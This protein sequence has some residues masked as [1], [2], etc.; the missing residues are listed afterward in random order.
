MAVENLFSQLLT[1][2]FDV[3]CKDR[4]DL[5]LVRG[6]ANPL[7]K[8]Y[9][10]YRAHA[11]RV[12]DVY[13]ESPDPEGEV[14]TKRLLD[15]VA[16]QPAPPDVK[17][18][19][20]RRRMSEDKS[21]LRRLMN[22]YL[23]GLSA[24]GGP[25]ERVSL[26]DMDDLPEEWEVLK[27]ILI[28]A[29]PGSRGKKGAGSATGR[30]NYSYASQHLVLSLR[31]VSRAKGEMNLDVLLGDLYTD[32][33]RAMKRNAPY[34]YHR[35]L[36]IEFSRM[37]KR[38]FEAVGL[39]VPKK[40]VG[41]R[42]KEFPEPLKSQVERYQV[43]A[44]DGLGSSEK[45]RR[46]ARAY[47]LKEG[48]Y[49]ESTIDSAIA[50]VGVCLGHIT[51]AKGERIERL[52]VEDL[53]ATHFVEIMNDAGKVIDVR[54]VNDNTEI[55]RRRQWAEVTPSKR[56]EFDSGTFEQFRSNLIVVAAVNGYEEH[57]NDFRKGYRVQLDRATRRAKKARKKKVFG[58]PAVDAEILRLSREVFKIV[59]EGSFKMSR[60][61]QDFVIHRRMTKILL[62]VNMA[63]L[64]YLGYRQQCLRRCR[65]GEHV[66]FHADGSIRFDFPEDVTKNGKHVRITL[67]PEEHGATHGVLL[68]I[69]WRYYKDVY[70]YILRRD[71]G[72][73]GHLFVSVSPQTGNFRKYNHEE[74]FE[75]YFVDWGKM[76][77]R[78]ETFPGA[79]ELNLN[80]NP[81]FFRGLCVDWLIEEL[82]W[83]RDAVA[84]FIGDEPETLKEYINENMIHDATKLLTRSNIVLKAEMAERERP[85]AEAEFRA[86]RLE[87]EKALRVK[88][89]QV[90]DLFDQLRMIGELF[91]REKNEKEELLLEIR[92]LREAVASAGDD[93]GKG[94]GDVPATTRPRRKAR[95]T[96]RRRAGA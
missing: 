85:R 46:V 39:P 55:Y 13:L 81:H 89:E 52:G 29:D 73:E 41:L 50:A 37:R 7:L 15:F 57:I 68:E 90:Q 38:Y 82:G 5:E 80:L 11:L 32:L 62:L 74:G 69:L 91:E 18:G 42:L 92:R 51:A 4:P 44:R 6:K 12:S 94:D 78:Y 61:G 95:P 49:R 30:E 53:I 66:V 10:E 1:K 59:E 34:P 83:S 76:H 72:V 21:A 8:A 40:L 88:E 67:S 28:R 45:L 70:P 79:Q 25:D 23:S 71:A 26:A 16:A 93:G 87:Y 24:R 27:N 63:V 33:T 77:L 2:F 84:T 43:V 56:A 75:I 19:R 48:P 65:V 58:R 36:S 86:K 47:V 3:V 54:P 31:E 60:P 22:E 14:L 35:D 64:R 20:H 9:E 96:S 17:P